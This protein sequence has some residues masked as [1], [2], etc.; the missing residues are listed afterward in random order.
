ML[1]IGIIIG[2]NRQN[3]V[4]DQIGKYVLEIANELTI[5]DVDFEIVDLIDYDMKMF[6]EPVSPR[7]LDEYSSAEINAWSDKIVSLDGFIFI[8]PEYNRGI[9]APLKSAIDQ[10]GAKAEW[11][12]KAARIISHGSTMGISATVQLRLTLFQFDIATLGSMVNFD[13][14][15]DFSDGKFTP[16][17]FHKNKTKQLIKNVVAWAG[18]MKGIRE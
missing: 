7:L 2:S 17:P 5:T 12:N 1:K 15:A 18:A 10:L 9:P 4:S 13:M 14:F 11:N 6:N 8:T 3:R 16:R